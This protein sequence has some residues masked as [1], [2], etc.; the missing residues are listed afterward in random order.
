M[1][2]A[3][4]IVTLLASLSF[5]SAAPQP[6]IEQSE[7]NV[8][9]VLEARQNIVGLEL[10]LYSDR[11]CSGTSWSRRVNIGSC[12]PTN[13]GFSSVRIVTKYENLFGGPS[14]VTIFTRNDCGCPTCGS[15]GFNTD[16]GQCLEF[17]EFVGNAISV[18]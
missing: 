3:A 2:L 15:H 18:R 6:I 9:A 11:G 8:T 5:T 13:P 4:T 16:P 1:R 7:T 17:P 14:V 10:L 12:A